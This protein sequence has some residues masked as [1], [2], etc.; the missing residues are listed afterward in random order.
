MENILKI[1]SLNKS[2]GKTRALN[3]F[4]LSVEK[5]NVFGVLGPNGSG[6]TTLLGII[7]DI[8]KADSGNYSWFGKKINQASDRLRIGSLLE[9]PTF[10]PYMSGYSNL[11]IVAEV[12]G[13]KDYDLDKLLELVELKERSK[14]KFSTYSLGMKQRLAIA[15]ALLNDPDV[16]ILD[17]PT[18]G[19]DPQGIADIRNLIISLAENGMTII[20][21]SHILDE[22]E[23]ICSHV[24]VIRNGHNLFTGTVEELTRKDSK[25]L[26][27]S[28][29]NQELVSLMNDSD[30]IHSVKTENG[31]II[32]SLNEGF[33]T[34]AVNELAFKNNIVLTHLS[35]E[36]SNLEQEFL[37][38][39]QENDATN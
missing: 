12:K 19:L 7:L 32:L 15:A 10:Y 38:I 1:E 16:L 4:S 25:I 14:S 13:L 20:V 22:I 24:S 11:R 8:L 17:E 3:D 39:L 33:D 34:K 35:E 2:Y 37:K 5:G 27:S 30:I 36:K 28:D 26:V 6:K 29:N 23:R 9:T 18:N 31:K 21:A